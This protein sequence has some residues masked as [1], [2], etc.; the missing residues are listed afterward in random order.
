MAA[1]QDSI[2]KLKEQYHDSYPNYHFLDT[3]L[4]DRLIH[5][6]LPLVVAINWQRHRDKDCKSSI[7]KVT[8][9]ADYKIDLID[10]LKLVL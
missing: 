1:N 8:G 7:P 9:I 2:R 5:T 10:R 6:T 4:Q 3:Q